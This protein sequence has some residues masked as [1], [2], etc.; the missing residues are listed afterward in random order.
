MAF[1]IGDEVPEGLGADVVVISPSALD[2]AT[3][4]TLEAAAG[5]GEEAPPTEESEEGLEEEAA[6]TPEQQAA[7]E[8][9]GEEEH[10]IHELQTMVQERLPEIEQM[11]TQCA[12]IAEKLPDAKKSA[13]AC[14]KAF[15]D[16]QKAHDKL[17][18]MAP[19]S[20]VAKAQALVQDFM[21]AL[22][23][24]T[25]A[26]E[27]AKSHMPD[28]NATGEEEEEDEEP[29]ANG[30]SPLAAWADRTAG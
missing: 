9:A 20:D 8:E 15:A 18:Q 24:A 12:N 28:L 26:C 17:M 5:G 13:K 14:E 3:L 21:A 10:G 29:A 22:D 6:E 1:F 23:E 2:E 11:V 27:E 19:A 16:A 25:A 30:E 7:E 4:A